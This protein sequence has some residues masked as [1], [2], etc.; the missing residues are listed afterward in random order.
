MWDDVKKLLIDSI[1]VALYVTCT[2]GSSGSN[3][4]RPEEE[5]ET[6]IKNLKDPTS[7][8]SSKVID[9]LLNY[10]TSVKA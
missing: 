8:A 1:V 10:V 2:S 4:Q 5:T 3:L 7:K 6:E 9:M